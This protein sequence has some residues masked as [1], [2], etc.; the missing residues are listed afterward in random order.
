MTEKSEICAK[1]RARLIFI[2]PSDFQQKVLSERTA[3]KRDG[4]GH[5][6]QSLLKLVKES[7]GQRTQD[8]TESKSEMFYCKGSLLTI[9]QNLQSTEI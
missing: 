3:K 4:G 6:V 2:A 1:G 5:V 7:S 9:Q 8:C